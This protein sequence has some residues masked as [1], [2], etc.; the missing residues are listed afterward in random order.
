VESHL[1][2]AYRKLDITS[3]NELGAVL[4]GDPTSGEAIPA[5]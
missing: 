2:N 1:S 3:R 5:S 4:E